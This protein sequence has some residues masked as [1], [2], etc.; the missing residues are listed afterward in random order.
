MFYLSTRPECQFWLCAS[1]LQSRDDRKA[2]PTRINPH[3]TSAILEN[4]SIK[5]I[6]SPR[7]T[8]SLL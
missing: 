6:I 3:Q 5:T 8:S 2:L 1:A 4:P 7:T